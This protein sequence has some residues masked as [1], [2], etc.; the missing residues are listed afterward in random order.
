MAIKKPDNWENVKAA[1]EREKLPVGAYICKILKAEVRAYDGR[2]GSTFEKLEIA[3]DISEGDFAGH[4]KKDFDS[5]RAEDK[6]WKGV[7]RQYLPKDDGTENDEWTK[8]ALKALI[9]AVEESTVGYHFDF[10]HEEQ[11]KGKQVGILFRNEQWAMGTRSG[12]KVQPFKALAVEKV[13]SGKFTIPNDKPN[14]S[15]VN[16]DVNACP[17]DFAAIDDDTEDLPF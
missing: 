15:A 7:L 8:S 10:E 17:E 16:I 12:W 2:D 3:F 5:Q 14:K 13:R 1:A 6:K 11:L 4:Y 9:E